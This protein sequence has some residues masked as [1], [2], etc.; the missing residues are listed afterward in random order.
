MKS[1]SNKTFD[2][3]QPYKVEFT[4]NSTTERKVTLLPQLLR[5]TSCQG[6]SMTAKP[7]AGYGPK[8]A[9]VA[10]VGRNPGAQDVNNK[11]PFSGPAGDILNQMLRRAGLDFT[12]C[13]LTNV[14]KCK[15]QHD[16]EPSIQSRTN[17][18]KKW[19]LPELFEL[20]NLK[21]IVLLGN[22]ALRAFEKEASITLV[23]GQSW[24]WQTR[25]EVT[26]FASFSP[27]Q[28][29]GPYVTQLWA[30]TAKLET[31]VKQLREAK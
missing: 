4:V 5:C 25:P 10:L 23:H 20:P 29:I 15:T 31:L 16:M 3:H 28:N 13:Y 19:L 6:R 22:T 1:P 8:T 18:Y 9:Q 11:R 14:V 30:D 24:K 27:S 21:L 17:C 26:L 2:P 7:V 12:E